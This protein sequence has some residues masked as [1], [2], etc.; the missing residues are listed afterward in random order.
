METRR[1]VASSAYVRNVG[2]IM[3]SAS[4]LLLGSAA[5]R[6]HVVLVAMLN[7]ERWPDTL[8]VSDHRMA[9]LTGL[10]RRTVAKARQEL[11]E[12]NVVICRAE[13]QGSQSRWVYRTV[14]DQLAAQQQDT[15]TDMGV[16]TN[17]ATDTSYILKEENR[18]KEKTEEGRRETRP[19]S[20]APELLPLA[21]LKDWMLSQ[22]A[23]VEQFCQRNRITLSVLGMELEQFVN[24]LS[25]CGH[26]GKP[27]ADALGHFGAWY[28]RRHQQHVAREQAAHLVQEEWRQAQADEERQRQ[29]RA[30][31][32]LQRG[33][34]SW[35]ASREEMRRKA[36]EG[37]ASA[38]MWLGKYEYLTNMSGKPCPRPEPWTWRNKNGEPTPAALKAE[39]EERASC[40]VAQSG[41]GDGGNAVAMQAGKEGV[42]HVG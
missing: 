8:A 13:G 12:A 14:V 24:H 39:E 15:P 17:M 10:S 22:N 18:R 31:E 38:L 26:V 41:R 6:M 20:S 37:D 40:H 34:A 25:N 9:E 5:V 2:A 33:I 3:Q 23:W 32:E 29:L 1:K 28:D 27:A 16:A 7:R 19:G 30:E 21:E 4:S 35:R 36:A 11:V 42:R